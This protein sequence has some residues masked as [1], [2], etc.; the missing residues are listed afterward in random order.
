[1]SW[2]NFSKRKCKECENEFEVSNDTLSIN[3][4]NFGKCNKCGGDSVVIKPKIRIV[5]C[6]SLTYNCENCSA[7]EY[8]RS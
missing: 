8:C 5:G 6:N 2:Y 4:P 1:M 7:K 3:N